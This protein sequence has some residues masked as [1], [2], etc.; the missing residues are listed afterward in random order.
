MVYCSQC[1]K[2]SSKLLLLAEYCVYIS[3]D[4]HVIFARNVSVVCLGFLAIN[5]YAF[6][7]YVSCG[8]PCVS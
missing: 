7:T 1:M 3:N 2:K 6:I 4:A 5:V 8:R